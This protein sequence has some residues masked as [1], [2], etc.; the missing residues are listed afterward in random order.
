MTVAFSKASPVHSII[1]CNGNYKISF[2]DNYFYW[3]NEMNGNISLSVVAKS[4]SSI[5]N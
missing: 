1:I 4:H 2:K 5:L 3:Y